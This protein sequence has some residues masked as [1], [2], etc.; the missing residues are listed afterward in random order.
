MSN[1]HPTQWRFRHL[2][3]GQV[4]WASDLGD[5]AVPVDSPEY[6]D[7]LRSQ[8]FGDNE[9]ANEGENSML[10]V[11]FRNA[12]APSGFFIRLYNSAPSEDDGLS[13]LTD[14]PSGSGYSPQSVARS[15]GGWPTLAL[16]G[17]DWQIVSDV[18]TFE[19]SGGTIGP[20]SHGVL[21]TSSDNSGLLI[22][23]RPL[24]TSRT[25]TD[26][27]SLNVEFRVKLD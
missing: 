21:A 14:E 26:G 18:V 15:A 23:Y 11:Y 6:Q 10:A 2:R 24:S 4:I 22:A 20:V 3:G 1:F 7:L 13:D 19:A 17:G 27:D 16:D 5:L 8:P 12:T 25:L 9:L